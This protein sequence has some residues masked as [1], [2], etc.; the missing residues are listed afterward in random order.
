MVTQCDMKYTI[1]KQSLGKPQYI[2]LMENYIYKYSS[3][4][5]MNITHI[6]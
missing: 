2:M 3:K 6:N 1:Q 4:K 5:K